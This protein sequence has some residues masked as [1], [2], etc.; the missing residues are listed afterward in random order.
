MA[1]GAERDQVLFGVMTRVTAKLFVV[2]LQVRHRA[3]GLT[4]PAVTAQD[5]LTESLV[6]RRIQR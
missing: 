5:L 4:P 2:D 3:T 6:R 1:C